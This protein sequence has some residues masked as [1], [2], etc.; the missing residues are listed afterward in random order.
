MVLPSGASATLGR[1]KMFGS[2]GSATVIGSDH[3]VPPSVDRAASTFVGPR[4]PLPMSVGFVGSG[5]KGGNSMLKVTKLPSGRM[6]R[7]PS[8]LGRADH[9]RP[10][11][12]V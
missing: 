4:A 9:V 6:R 11:S 1:T 12:V 3:V 5:T 8:P 10:P 7:A 2:A